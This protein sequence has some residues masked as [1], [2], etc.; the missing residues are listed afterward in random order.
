MNGFGRE[1]FRKRMIQ[2]IHTIGGGCGTP[3][4]FFNSVSDRPNLDLVTEK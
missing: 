1:I 2:R 3:C 4:S